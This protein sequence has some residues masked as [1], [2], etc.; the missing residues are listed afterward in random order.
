MAILKMRHGYLRLLMLKLE[1]PIPDRSSQMTQGFSSKKEPKKD[2]PRMRL[3]FVTSAADISQ[4]PPGDRPEIALIGRSNSGK[5]SM[6]NAL[7]GQKKLAKVSSTPGKTRLLNFFDAGEAYRIVDMPGYGFA[8]RS[9]GEQASWQDMIEPYLAQREALVGL[10]L[11]MDVRRDWTQDEQ[12]MVDW[13]EPQNLPVVVGLTKCDKVSKNEYIKQVRKIRIVSGIEEVYATSALD[14]TGF[15][16]LE[17]YVYREWI[18][19]LVES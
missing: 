2:K 13:M 12:M 11:L 1:K 19:N 4:C 3:Q 17:D 7:S 16:E 18:K 15:A 9:G 6:I 8:S 5:S 14:K 10:I